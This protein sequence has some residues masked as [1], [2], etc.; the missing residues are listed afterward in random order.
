MRNAPIVLSDGQMRN[1]W[2]DSYRGKKLVFLSHNA[3]HSDQV[4]RV[5]AQMEERGICC[6]L[7]HKDIAPSTIWQ[8]EIVNALNTMDIALNTMDIFIGFVT[9]DF[10]SGSWT[11]Q[12]IGYAAQRDVFRVFVKLGGQDPQGLVAREQALNTD[13]ND[14]AN[15]IISQLRR[16]RKLRP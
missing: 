7:A 15:A 5:K 3:Q 14:A 13:W 1:V 16:A 10:H 8:D 4:A 11:N 12:E 2:G 9:D 6:F